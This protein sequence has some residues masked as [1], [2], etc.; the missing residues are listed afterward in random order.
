LIGVPCL[1][2]GHDFVPEFPKLH[3]R[4]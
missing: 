2:G 4:Q 3:H 1:Q